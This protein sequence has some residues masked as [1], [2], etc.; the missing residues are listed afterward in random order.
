MVPLLLLK[1][2]KRQFVFNQHCHLC[3]LRRRVMNGC[4]ADEGLAIMRIW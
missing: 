2:D 1:T 4:G 3:I